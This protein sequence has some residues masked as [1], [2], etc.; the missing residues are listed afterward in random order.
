MQP[1]VLAAPIR[2]RLAEGLQSR[3]SRPPTFALAVILH[4]LGALSAAAEGVDVT[5]VTLKS[6]DSGCLASMDLRND[7]QQDIIHFSIDLYLLDRDG[8]PLERQIVDIAPLPSGR[9]TAAALPLSTACGRIDAV[10]IIGIPDCRLEG[11]RRQ[12]DC[13]STLTA[14]SGELTAATVEARR[15]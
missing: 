5:L 8:N 2:V 14:R 12:E 11:G 1:V 6:Q 13:F 4:L 7:W 9:V 3:M 15:N 10:R